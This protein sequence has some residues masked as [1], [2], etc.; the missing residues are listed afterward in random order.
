MKTRSRTVATIAIASAGALLLAGCAGGEEGAA[1][2]PEE[3]VSLNFAWWGNDDRADRYGK[4]IDAFNEDYPNITINS[5]FSDFPSY[6]EKRQTEVAGGGLPDV[7]QFSDSYLRQYAEPGHVLDLSTVADQID[8]TTFDDALLGTGQLNGVQYSLPTGYSVWANFVND[9][10]LAEY[11]LDAP[12]GGTSFGEFDEWMADVTTSTDGALYGGTDY[13]QRIQAFELVLRANGENL[14]TEDGQ[15]G[16]AEDELRDFWTSGDDLRDGVTVPQQQL[17]EISPI[18]G[19]GSNLTATEMSWSNFLGGYLADSGSSAISLVAPPT[20]V[21]GSKD[22]YQQGGLQIAIAENTEHP[23][24]AAI[25]LNYIVNSP[26]AGEIFGTTLGFPA[27][28]SKL[29]GTT[30]EG[31]DAQVADYLESVADRVGEA[32]PVPVVGYGSL[33]QTFWDLGKSLGLGVISVDDAVSS[34][35]GEAEVILG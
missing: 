32:P 9:E 34:F 3:E 18:S 6:W 4:L 1:Y 30:L 22:L 5:T 27:S 23:E 24:A 13:T 16:F 31:V 35:F 19:F 29:S 28:S 7:F 8:F 33:E 12:E 10:L 26:Q 25:F 20:A 11:G 14:Y 21:E 15:L 2:D 17:E